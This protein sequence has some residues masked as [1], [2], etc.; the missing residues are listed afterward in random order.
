[1]KRII[2]VAGAFAGLMLLGAC[3]AVQNAALTQG[4]DQIRQAKD[5][6]AEV[7]K[8]GVCAMSIGAYHRVNNATER[9]ALD[10]LCG[11]EWTRA[12]TADDVQVL[13]GL[14]DLLVPGPAPE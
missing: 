3:T 1:M 4:V 2:I 5:A 7:L 13:R 8:A 6:E 11:G 10:V 9:R 12:V 14:A